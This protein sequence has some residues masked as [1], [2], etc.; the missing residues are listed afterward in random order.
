MPTDT[1]TIAERTWVQQRS[2]R[3]VTV[4]C[5][6]CRGSLTVRWTVAANRSI[7]MF[8]RPGLQTNIAPPPSLAARHKNALGV[9]RTIIAGIGVAF[10]QEFQ[11]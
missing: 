11:Q 4:V 3:A 2:A 10:F 7:V 6:C 8:Y 5:D 1:A 9:S